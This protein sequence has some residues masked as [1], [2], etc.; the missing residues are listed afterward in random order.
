M[1]YQY[2]F[3]AEETA[4]ETRLST[5]CYHSP[6]DGNWPLHCH[7]YYELSYVWSGERY[8][9]Y[10]GNYRRVGPGS[11]FFME[12]LVIHGN[13]NITPVHDMVI[14]FSLDFLWASSASSCQ[15]NNMILG[16]AQ[17]EVP[18]IEVQEDHKI[19]D[20]LQEL[21]LLCQQETDFAKENNPSAASIVHGWQRNILV[22]KLLT[23]LVDIGFLEFRD[24]MADLTQLFSLE[25]LIN[26]ILTH[27]SEIPDMTEA[28]LAVGMSY[29]SF[30][31]FF[32]RTTGVSYHAYC[33]QLRLQYAENSLIHSNKSIAEIARE[34][35]IDT[36]SY[37]TRMFKQRY[38]I[39]PMQFRQ[40]HK[41]R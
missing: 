35:G 6:A 31:R 19:I 14:Q 20:I 11:L 34:I 25:T 21:R 26:R 32:K 17:A 7:A 37:F 33:N 3:Q 18:Y 39:S 16:L 27:P 13:Q 36:A 9:Q 38:G 29:Y 8:E 4:S 41:R 22:L 30:S 23:V 24:T 2:T 10:R 5:C 1:I 28:S 12:P 40:Q 15:K